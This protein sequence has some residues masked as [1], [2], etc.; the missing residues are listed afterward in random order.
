MKVSP[1]GRVEAF[2]IHSCGFIG[3]AAVKCLVYGIE[4]GSFYRGIGT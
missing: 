4:T 3:V 2:A 1:G